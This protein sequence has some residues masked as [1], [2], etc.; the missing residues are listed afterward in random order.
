MSANH[1]TDVIRRNSLLLPLL[2]APTQRVWNANETHCI[3]D[4][5]VVVVN[6]NDRIKVA[7]RRL[8]TFITS[9]AEI[10]YFTTVI[11]CLSNNDY[12]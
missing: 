9:A 12:Y 10:G 2:A 5:S 3:A 8:F 11:Q 6:R 4:H 1:R 7:V